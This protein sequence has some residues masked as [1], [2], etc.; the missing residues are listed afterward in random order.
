MPTFGRDDGASNEE[1]RIKTGWENKTG[2]CL[3]PKEF[4]EVI[5]SLL[6]V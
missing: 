1:Q 6:T 5:V 4:M 2:L 3:E